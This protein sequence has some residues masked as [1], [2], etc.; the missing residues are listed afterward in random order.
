[1]HGTHASN[2]AKQDLHNSRYA[3]VLWENRSNSQKIQ[4]CPTIRDTQNALMVP[5][6]GTKIPTGLVQA[7]NV[8]T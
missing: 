6:L 3:E 2:Q 4:K 1:M 8:T 5:I 7:Q